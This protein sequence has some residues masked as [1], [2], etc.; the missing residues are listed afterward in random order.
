MRNSM[1]YIDI[2]Q[3]SSPGNALGKDFF[4]SP[5]MPRGDILGFSLPPSCPHTRPTVF[6]LREV[7]SAHSLVDGVFIGELQIEVF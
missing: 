3:L 5:D 6:L 7:S 2:S 1:R 4:D